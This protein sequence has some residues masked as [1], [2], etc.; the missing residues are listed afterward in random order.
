MTVRMKRT[1]MK[2]AKRCSSH[3]LQAREQEEVFD[4][5]LSKTRS[6]TMPPQLGFDAW[7]ALT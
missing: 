6:A 5:E 7:V 3:I 1:S 2:V 4:A